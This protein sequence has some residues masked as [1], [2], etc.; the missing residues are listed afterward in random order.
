M[1]LLI[2]LVYK[3]IMPA[4]SNQSTV[5]TQPRYTHEIE[6]KFGSSLS[7]EPEIEKVKGFTFGT[8]EEKGR[9]DFYAE[10]KKTTYRLFEDE[11]LYD[12]E[13]SIG[14][15][16]YDNPYEDVATDTYFET[17]SIEVSYQRGLSIFSGSEDFNTTFINPAI[18]LHWSFVT[19]MRYFNEKRIEERT[20]TYSGGSY[21]GD[22]E[23][24][25]YHQGTNRF[26]A[27][28]IGLGFG[29]ITY[30]KVKDLL[31]FATIDV[32]A[33]QEFLGGTTTGGSI[34]SS[35]GVALK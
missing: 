2:Y 6:Y 13:T 7:T 9:G 29:G 1:L 30:L 19:G 3:A 23:S 24:K 27:L 5:P 18:G 28:Y 21:N 8:F 22:A 10:Y 35:I 26:G 32:Q 16:S 34:I 11:V 4:T 33:T 15:Y 12:S 31:M 25:S 14:E 20:T 17:Y